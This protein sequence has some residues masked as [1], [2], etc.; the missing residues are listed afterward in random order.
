MIVKM[1]KRNLLITFMFWIHSSTFPQVSDIKL[2]LPRFPW[3]DCNSERRHFRKQFCVEDPSSFIT[4]NL[5]SFRNIHESPCTITEIIY[6][7]QGMEYAQTAFILDSFRFHNERFFILLYHYKRLPIPKYDNWL[8]SCLNCQT[9][10]TN[11]KKAAYHD[12]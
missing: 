7:T 10:A 8:V 6:S 9:L 11:S 2:K 1:T 4:R 3:K 12:P 5:Q